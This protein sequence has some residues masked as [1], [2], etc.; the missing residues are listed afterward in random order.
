[1]CEC[2]C[3]SFVPDFQFP[4]P[5]GEVYYLS[6]RPPCPECDTPVG[7][8]IERCRIDDVSHEHFRNVPTLPFIPFA[9][10]AECAVP[11]VAPRPLRQ[12]LAGEMTDTE[13]LVDRDVAVA[14]ADAMRR[15]RARWD[16]VREDVPK[17]PRPKRAGKKAGRR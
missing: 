3:A 10:W 17:P 14:L 7:I 8:L 2:G 15:T 5:R 16:E 1:M 4:A 11:M 6:I 12:Q 9:T 13:D